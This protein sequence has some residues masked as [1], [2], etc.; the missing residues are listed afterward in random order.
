LT[1]GD[2]VVGHLH[3]G[4][5]LRDAKDSVTVGSETFRDSLADTATGSGDEGDARR[6]RK[7]HRKFLCKENTLL[8]SG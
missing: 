8:A 1:L 2:D 5:G 4:L 3:A 6:V 7:M